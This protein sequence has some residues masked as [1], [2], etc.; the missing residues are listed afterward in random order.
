MIRIESRNIHRARIHRRIR[1]KISGSPERPRLSVFRSLK[2]IYAQLIDDSTGCT[3]VAASTR[4]RG[5]RDLRGDNVTAAGEVGRI[6]AERAKE[7]GI[8][9]VVFDRA[10]Y[11]YHGRV[12][13]LAEAA[14][15]AGLEF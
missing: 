10:G 1:R 11:R 14:R 5:A 7:K 13:A 9:R 2:N 12:R 3:L 4:D 15:K 8:V 6:V